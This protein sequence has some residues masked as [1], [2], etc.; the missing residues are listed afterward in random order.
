MHAEQNHRNRRKTGLAYESAAAGWLEKN[1][2]VI[3]ARNYSSRFGEIDLIARTEESLLFVEVRY[4]TRTSFGLPEET[5]TFSKQR[6]IC[7]TAA[8][9][10]AA[11]PGLASLPCRFDVIA[12]SGEGQLRHYP[13][14]FPYLGS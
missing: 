7:R 14:A 11:H 13:D 3:L 4:R 9:Y 10:L 2:A 8:C 5:V 12:L 1:G 6:K